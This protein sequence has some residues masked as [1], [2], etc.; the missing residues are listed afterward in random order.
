M[1]QAKTSQFADKIFSDMAGAMGMGMAYLGV[2]TGLFKVM[3][4][5]GPVTTGELA[6]ALGMIPRYV[7]EWLLG[8]TAAG[9]L[10]CDSQ[11]GTF[12]L[13][14]EHAF[15]LASEGTD[16]YAGGLPYGAIS[17]LW[18]APRVARAFRDGGGVDFK[19]FPED[20]HAALDLMNRGNYDNRLVPAW[21]R[22]MPTV[23]DALNGGGS[24]LDV[25]CGAGR[26]SLN[27]ARAF[28][29]ARFMGV[30][31]DPRSIKLAR[32]E[33]D[34]AGLAERVEFVAGT[35]DSLPPRL[36][37]DLI[38]LC[39]CLHDLGTP[40]ETLGMIRERLTPDGTLFIM[41][42]KA[43]DRPEDNRNSVATMFYGFSLFHCMTQSLAKGG[44]GL[45]TCMGPARTEA[46]IREAGF[47]RF[48]RLPIKSRV[49]LFYEVRA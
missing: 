36:K 45:G 24:A 38:T 49:N 28:P 1:D 2:K 26:V 22:E 11:A 42:P 17:F 10:E 9:Y 37:F 29:C 30:D 4:E 3:A 34:K 35:I 18:A 23:T 44:P 41:E 47:T 15:L 21:M 14:E 46:L 31:T 8:M 27:L 6:A 33:A 39:D 16:H 20:C 7:E 25:G 40:E 19:E 5:R 13:P 48:K 43:A 32:A 12:S